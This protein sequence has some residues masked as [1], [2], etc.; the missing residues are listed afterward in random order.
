M[1]KA[2]QP[3]DRQSRTSTQSRWAGM[4]RLAQ[5]LGRGPQTH[6]DVASRAW[7]ECRE[8]RERAVPGLGVPRRVRS[9]LASARHQLPRSAESTPVPLHLL[10]SP[11][12]PLCIHFIQKAP[13]GSGFHS[14]TKNWGRGHEWPS[15]RQRIELFLVSPRPT[16]PSHSALSFAVPRCPPFLRL[17]MVV[18]LRPW[19]PLWRSP[20]RAGALI[21]SL[22]TPD[23]RALP[24]E[25]TRPLRT[26]PLEC[27]PAAG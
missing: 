16:G 18:S 14:R 19:S 6:R 24:A 27:V 9:G 21:Q 7:A 22:G 13:Y 3:G 15:L 8:Q 10:L 25:L 23:S 26:P 2:T 17:S 12:N 5:L 20:I 4:R 1:P 11:L